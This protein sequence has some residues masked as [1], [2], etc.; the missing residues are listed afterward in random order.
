MSYS[1]V[2]IP[3][4]VLIL[5]QIIKLSTDKIKGNLN[6]KNIFVTRGGMP[7]SHA[8]FAVSLATVIA[9]KYGFASIGFAIA[10]AFAL[11]II[12]D[13]LIFRNVLG[14]Q[15]QILKYLI[16][17]LPEEEKQNLP[18]FEARQ[19]HTPLE[20]VIGIIWGIGITWILYYLFGLT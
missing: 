6:L 4:I 11:I 18:E 7:S 3:L 1:L 17:K 10:F 8:A 5:T 12:N 2:L 16:K 9:L 14:K 15:S 20:V 13:A 19:G